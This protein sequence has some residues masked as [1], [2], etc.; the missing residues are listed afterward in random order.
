MATTP[1]REDRVLSVAEVSRLVREVL[2]TGIG[3]VSVEGEVSGFKRSANG[4]CYFSLLGTDPAG[5]K[6]CLDCVVW[7]SARIAAAL[8][9][10]NGRKVVATGRMT[11]YAGSGSSRYQLSADSVQEAGQG[12]LLRR[13]EEL[14]VRLA[15][16][17]LFDPARRKPIPFLPR[18]IGVVTSLRGAAVRDIVRTILSRYPARIV[19]V[20]AVVQGEGAAARIAEGIER[21]HA[22]PGID[23]IIVGRGGGSLE[24]LWAFNEEVLVRAVA[25]ATIPIISAV[26]HEVDHVLTDAAADERAAT[27]TAAGQ[28]VVPSMEAVQDLLVELSA[29]MGQGLRHR[30]ETSAQ[31][32]DDAAGRLQGA[33]SRIVPASRQRLDLLAARLR[34]RDPVRHVAEERRR[35]EDVRARLSRAAGHL[36]DRQRA[37]LEGL[38]LR[39]AP[40]SPYAPLDRGYALARTPDGRLVTRSDQVDA[41]DRVDVLLGSG[42][43]DCEVRAAKPA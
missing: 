14:K 24:D 7:R 27:P 22:V 4:H 5:G 29:R 28:R 39:L 41:G 6:A 13:L 9:L 36:L 37:S 15:A 17:G 1:Q 33:A 20:D 34:A 8:D 26:G 18:A 23:V 2:E 21:L 11:S 30:V 38:R 19:L 25:A 3:R 12:D 42:S 35:L 40:L 10:V 43:L 16:E 31:R 32:L